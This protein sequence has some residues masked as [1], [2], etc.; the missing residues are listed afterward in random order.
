MKRQK[1][2]VKV[3]S[4]PQLEERLLHIPWKNSEIHTPKNS[5]EPSLE[6]LKPLVEEIEGTIPPTIQIILIYSYI[7]FF[8]FSSSLFC[9]LPL[10]T[11]APRLVPV[12]SIP[13]APN[14][15]QAL[16]AKLFKGSIV[17]EVQSLAA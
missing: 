8:F 13:S 12:E 16:P 1:E 17:L 15:S 3:T 6:A 14:L 2:Y 7:F 11:E 10:S 5:A 9:I 4:K